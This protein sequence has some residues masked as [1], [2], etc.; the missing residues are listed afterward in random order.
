MKSWAEGDKKYK[1]KSDAKRN[2]KSTN[3]RARPQL[4]ELSVCEKELKE[5]LS[6]K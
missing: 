1:E 6:S 5:R 2:K 3:L 4:A